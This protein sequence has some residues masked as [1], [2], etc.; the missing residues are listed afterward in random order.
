MIGVSADEQSRAVAA[1]NDVCQANLLA[2]ADGGGLDAMFAIADAQLRLSEALT[3]A[4]MARIMGLMGKEVGFLTDRDNSDKGPYSMETVKECVIA[5]AL[6]GLRVTGNEFNIIAGRCYKAVNG[7]FRQIREYP[8]LT[9]FESV[10]EIPQYVAGG[11][12]ASVRICCTWK[13]N[14]EQ[15]SLTGIYPVKVNAGMGTDGIIGKAKHRAYRKVWARLSGMPLEPHP[16][17][18]RTIEGTATAAIETQ[19]ATAGPVDREAENAGAEG[20]PR[21]EGQQ[22]NRPTLGQEYRAEL[23]RAATVAETGAVYDRWC[24][25]DSER[26][27]PNGFDAWAAEERNRR[28]AEIRQRGGE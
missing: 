12:V 9:N 16:D 14:G 3:P 25:P 5:A 7:T 15:D 20:Q 4:I 23:S 24:G 10:E 22:G 2:S 17:D 19:P 8:R 13:L 6:R 1:Y 11:A 21:A 27:L 28:N 26:E 18:D